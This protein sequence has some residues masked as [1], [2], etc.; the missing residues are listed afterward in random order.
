[1]IG[2]HLLLLKLHGE[3]ADTFTIPVDVL[4]FRVTH[5]HN[6]LLRILVF[7]NQSSIDCPDIR[8]H[9]GKPIG[10]GSAYAYAFFIRDAD[11]DPGM[12]QTVH[13]NTKFG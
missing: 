6:I 8:K 2:L 12:W 10:P 7:T 4:L 11:A 5:C 1:M 13:V 9:K 3:F